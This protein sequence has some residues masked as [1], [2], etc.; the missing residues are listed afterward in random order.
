MSNGA[1][2]A[3]PGR[4]AESRVSRG[5]RPEVGPGGRSLRILLAEDNVVNEK[6]AC[7]I[8]KKA[9]HTVEVA[10]D[11]REAVRMMGAGSFDLVL[12]DVQMPEMDGL[13]RPPRFGRWKE[14]GL[15]HTGDR[16]D[17]ARHGW[18]QGAVSGGG[19]GWI[20]DEA[21]SP[22]AVVADVGAISGRAGTERGCG[23]AL[24]E[25]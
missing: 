2:P 3:S 9:G 21:H 19:D 4:S 14:H 12:M 24:I 11:G 10:R 18:I 5:S 16:H 23:S 13:K 8:L 15:P 22:R 6:V 17:G 1:S 25:R 7:A 20:R